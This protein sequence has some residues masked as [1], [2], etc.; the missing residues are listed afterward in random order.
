MKIKKRNLSKN[1]KAIAPTMPEVDVEIMTGP[2]SPRLGSIDISPDALAKLEEC[3]M[4][5][6]F[7][8][9]FHEWTEGYPLEKLSLAVSQTNEIIDTQIKSKISMRCYWV[10][11]ITEV[12]NIDGQN[13]IR[14]RIML[15]ED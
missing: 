3:A 6:D 5:P 2:V 7:I 8:L 11:V 13:S 14:T 10:L 1:K 9:Y 15:T 12:V 4:N